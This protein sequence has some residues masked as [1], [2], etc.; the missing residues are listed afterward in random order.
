[1]R[2]ISLL[3]VVAIHSVVQR[4]KTIYFKIQRD[5]YHPHK[6]TCSEVTLV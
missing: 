6:K 5:G 2:C 1:M 3:H 4:L